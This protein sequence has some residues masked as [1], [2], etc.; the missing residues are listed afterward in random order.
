MY[1]L[2][3]GFP[4]FNAENDNAI[5]NKVSKAEY[6]FSSPEW[7]CVSDQARNLVGRLLEPN[8]DLRISAEEALS[9]PWFRIM[10]GETCFDKPLAV[11]TLENLK[12]FRVYNQI[13]FLVNFD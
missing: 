13:E 4:P 8:P 9:D 6:S 7:D 5:L 2:L 10:L 11:S 12:H 1:V 3:C